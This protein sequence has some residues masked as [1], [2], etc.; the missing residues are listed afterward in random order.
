M[1]GAQALVETMLASDV[2]VCFAN[3]GTSEMHF[4]AALDTHPDMRCILCLFEGGVT[5]AADGYARMSGN[6]AGTLLHLGPG[7]A[8]SWANLHNAR[9]GRTGIVNVVGDHAGYHLKHDAPLQSDLDGV[10]GSVSHWV[11]RATDGSVVAGI[12]ADAIQA[13]RG[14]QIAT[15]ILQA[16]AAWSDSVSGPTKAALPAEK[17]RPDAARIA[18]AA[19]ALNQPGAAL[20]ASGPALFGE[21]ADLAGQIAA[22]TG[23]RLL[24][25]FFAPR[26]ALGQGAVRFEALPYMADVTADFLQG[27]T[28]IVLV[29]EDP[30]VNFFAYPGKPST[31]EPAGCAIERLCFGDWDIIWTLEALA[32]AVGVEGSRVHWRFDRAMSAQ[33]A[34]CVR[35]LPRPTGVC[36]LRRWISHVS[37]AMPVDGGTRA[38]GHHFRHHRQPGLS[39]PAS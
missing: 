13:A 12:G 10:A 18:A 27:L 35:G 9:K 39:D 21:G 23:C 11:R 28:R 2:T 17:H 6:V 36:H 38:D 1:N 19:H 14:G 22:R 7:F 20:L 34:W 37:G 3:P 5:G 30:P 24:A 32:Q 4:V 25:P 29:G 16:D 31:P 8:N 15:V 26:L 33:C